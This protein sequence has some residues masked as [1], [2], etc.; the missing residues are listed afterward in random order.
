MPPTGDGLPPREV[1][2]LRSWIADGAVLPVKNLGLKP[3]GESP[4]SR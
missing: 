3:R 2:V 1:A 4:R